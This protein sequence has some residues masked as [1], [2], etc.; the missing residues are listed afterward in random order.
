M[1]LRELVESVLGRQPYV[2]AEMRDTWG[3]TGYGELPIRVH[4]VD[5]KS[6]QPRARLAQWYPGA[7]LDCR[8]PYTGF[9]IGRP[10][11]VP[12]SDVA[13]FQQTAATNFPQYSRQLVALS[14]MPTPGPETIQAWMSRGLAT[15]RTQ[16]GAPG[17]VAGVFPFVPY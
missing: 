5:T 3:V 16:Q 14:P 13:W 1:G 9:L 17:N 2:S 15:F 6:Y 7:L 8:V 4:D 12:E 10:G 11:S